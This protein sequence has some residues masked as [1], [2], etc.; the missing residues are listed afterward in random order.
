MAENGFVQEGRKWLFRINFF[1]FKS[2]W[3]FACAFQLSSKP[4][5]C[6]FLAGLHFV[7]EINEDKI[8]KRAQWTQQGQTSAFQSKKKYR[9][10]F[11]YKIEKHMQK[12]RHFWRKKILTEKVTYVP[13]APSH[14]IIN[15]SNM[16]KFVF[17]S[18][19]IWRYS[20]IKLKLPLLPQNA[21]K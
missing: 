5:P 12:F 2:A 9:T 19:N 4:F 17:F 1:S 20:K 21:L 6:I 3:M 18:L 7:S 14:S 16:L 11:F 10:M 13:L 8:S 15:C